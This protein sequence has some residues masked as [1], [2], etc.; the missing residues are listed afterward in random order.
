MAQWYRL[1]N[2]GKL[3]PSVRGQ[4]RTTVFRISASLSQPVHA[5]RLQQ[6]LENIMPRFPFFSVN[7]KRGVFW[8]FFQ[9][10]A[11]RPAVER[12]SRSPCMR[13]PLLRRGIF[14]FRIRCYDNRIGAEFSHALTDGTGGLVFLKALIAEYLHLSGV[15]RQ[16]CGSIPVPGSMPQ[17]GEADDAFR[18]YANP[19]LPAPL[20]RDK[21][22]HLPLPLE[23]KGRYRI[24]TGIM[25]IEALKTRAAEFNTGITDFL[26]AIMIFSFCQILN[27]MPKDLR[28]KVQAPIRINIPVNLR[29]IWPSPS[30]R[31]FFISVAPEIDPRLGEWQFE[32]I[33]ERTR[34][35]MTAET[36]RRILAARM[37]QFF[38]GEHNLFTR[39]IPLSIKNMFLPGL[40][41]KLGTSLYTS[42]LSNL[43][44][45]EMP[46]HLSPYIQCFDFIPPPAADEKVKAA[47]IGWKDHLHL[48]FG[49]VIRPAI[50]ELYVFRTLVS[51]GIPVKV[52]SN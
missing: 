21:A 30:L 33:L 8:Y 18:H 19:A 49:R 44:R 10:S 5:G 50:A 45:V 39:L 3:Y 9:E 32:E 34:L 46:G 4:R 35:Y 15:P 29:N 1:D 41:S 31:N 2:A 25:P 12:D 38:R 23:R 26:T 24:T 22:F 28:R 17:P 6:A 52:E 48:T 36:D 51:M 11:R 37:G 20:L 16:D 47:V 27:D 43:G 42:G 40:Y 14:P 7:L 13:Y